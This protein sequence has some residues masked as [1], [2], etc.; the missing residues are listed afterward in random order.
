MT[1]S[2]SL[3]WM[4]L[5]PDPGFVGTASDAVG[6]TPKYKLSVHPHLVVAR[7]VNFDATWY[8][9]DDLPKQGVSAYD[10]VDARVGWSRSRKLELAGGV[11]NLFHDREL[12]YGSVSGTS[13][14]T[15]VRTGVFGQVTWRP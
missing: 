10:R 12:E 14:A 6:D 1:L 3:F 11:Q 2:H 13:L 7:N 5:K 9:V 15:T 8:H 4:D